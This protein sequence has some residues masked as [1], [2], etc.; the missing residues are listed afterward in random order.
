MLS[1]ELPSNGLLADVAGR[2]LAKA[3]ISE[4]FL[5]CDAAKVKSQFTQAG[6]NRAKST[7]TICNY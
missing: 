7:T 5:K 4:F 3:V 2:A 1:A 6:S